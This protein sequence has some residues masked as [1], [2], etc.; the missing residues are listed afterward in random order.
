M[1]NY[2][3]GHCNVGVSSKL[4]II[5][6][7]TVSLITCN[8]HADLIKS[9]SNRA[10]PNTWV[11]P[12]VGLKLIMAEGFIVGSIVGFVVV[13]DVGKAVGFIEGLKVAPEVGWALG[14]AEGTTDGRAVGVA[15]ASAALSSIV[16]RDN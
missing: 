12:A 5:F 13:I 4:P 16:R 3:F 10:V 14:I 15:F 1:S 11:G 7:P 8:R 9:Y 6:S 2:L